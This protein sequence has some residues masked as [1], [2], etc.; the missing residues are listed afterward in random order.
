MTGPA[1]W[2]SASLLAVQLAASAV[3]CT[4]S[5]FVI[6]K[7]NGQTLQDVRIDNLAAFL[8]FTNLDA[9]YAEP[10]EAEGLVLDDLGAVTD[11]ELDAMGVKKL[12]HR[13]RFLR[14]AQQLRVV[15]DAAPNGAAKAKA[16]EKPRAKPSAADP[17]E[18]Q[19]PPPPPPLEDSDAVAQERWKRADG[20]RKAKA[21][22][23]AKKRLEERKIAGKL[24]KGVDADLAAAVE[25]ED[26][27]AVVE[28]LDAG[29]N[30][31]KYFDVSGEGQT[32]MMY[33]SISGYT[34]IANVLLDRGAD[35]TIGME[36]SGF[37]PIHGAAYAGQPDVVKLLLDHG[38]DALHR[39]KDGFIPMHRACW[40][41]TPVHTE[42]VLAFLEHGVDVMTT[43]LDPEY[44]NGPSR[45]ELQDG[46]MTPLNMSGMNPMTVGLLEAWEATGAPPPGKLSS[47]GADAFSSGHQHARHEDL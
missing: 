34:E 24:Q 41:S 26:I 37:T 17:P 2:L 18:E 38:V 40:G 31:D 9:S 6:T 30:I 21:K 15:A 27:D 20:I 29:A 35:L 8:E 23:D 1:P 28:A 43:A 25:N 4:A 19:T 39:H 47:W 14:F 42:S 33:A 13:S 46:M 5:H 44:G 7:D 12:M 3:L 45:Y 16:K 11:E 36:S 32:P 10:L 22:E